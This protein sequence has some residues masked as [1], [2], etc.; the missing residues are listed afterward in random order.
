[1]RVYQANLL[2]PD[3]R[4]IPQNL[5]GGVAVIRGVEKAGSIAAFNVLS[6]EMLK[7]FGFAFAW[8]TKNVDMRFA[9][10]LGEIFKSVF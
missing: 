5:V 1:M 2:K 9:V 7:E 6:D 8:T 4:A 10:F 3:F